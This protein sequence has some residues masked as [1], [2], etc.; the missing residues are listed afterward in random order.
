[1][2]LAQLTT[3]L[4]A[5]AEET[6]SALATAPDVAS[7]DAIELDVLGKKG[8]LTGVLRGIG[9]LPADDRPWRHRGGARRTTRRARVS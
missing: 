7:V 8:R 9:A 6:A 4:E 5:L 1:V 3:D 2:D